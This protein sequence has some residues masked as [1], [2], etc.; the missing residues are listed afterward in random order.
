MER[1]LEVC[2]IM[3]LEPPPISTVLYFRNNHLIQLK[4]YFFQ[5]YFSA[6]ENLTFCFKPKAEKIK[7][8]FDLP[9]E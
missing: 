8:Y 6:S 9:H 5:N 1:R 7:P 4:S 3:F 2:M